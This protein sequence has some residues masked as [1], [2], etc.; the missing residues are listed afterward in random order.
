MPKH[1]LFLIALLCAAVLVLSEG[2]DRRPPLDIVVN[3][4][5][6]FFLIK[7][8]Q[9]KDDVCGGE[10]LDAL[11]EKCLEDN[12]LEEP[13]EGE[14]EEEDYPCNLANLRNEC[15]ERENFAGD[16]FIL[17]PLEDDESK[18]TIT[19]SLSEGAQESQ[20]GLS[21]YFFND[22]VNP[23]YNYTTLSGGVVQFGR[24]GDEEEQNEVPRNSV[25]AENTIDGSHKLEMTVN[26]DCKKTVYAGFFMTLMFA[27]KY[28]PITLTVPVMCY[29]GGCDD[30]CMKHGKCIEN[31]GYCECSPP[32]NEDGKE[33]SVVLRMKKEEYCPGE[34]IEVEL[35]LSKVSKEEWYS[36]YPDW[37]ENLVLDWNYLRDIINSS[38]YELDKP[39]PPAD[40]GSTYSFSIPLMVNPEDTGGV[41]FS[42]YRYADDGDYDYMGYASFTVLRYDDPKCGKP[43]DTCVKSG[44]KHAG[45]KCNEDTG[46][47]ECAD[48]RNFWFDCSRGCEELTVIKDSEGVIDSAGEFQPPLYNTKTTCTWII[49]PEEKDFDY[50]SMSFERF[51]VTN[52]DR[53]KVMTLGKTG[54]IDETSM[55]LGLFSG[56]SVPDDA[57]YEKVEAFGLV[58][59][60]DYSGFGSGFRVKYKT[61]TELPVLG[62]ALG[63]SFAGAIIIIIIVV[64]IFYRR[65]TKSTAVDAALHVLSVPLLVPQSDATDTQFSNADEGFTTSSSDP[66]SDGGDSSSGTGGGTLRNSPSK[67]SLMHDPE[68]KKNT[69]SF[70]IAKQKVSHPTD[71]ES[72]GWT[73][74]STLDVAS[75]VLLFGL[76]SQAT[77]PVMED[78][79]EDVVFTN[80]SSKPLQ[81]RISHPVDENVY[82]CYAQPGM[83]TLLAGC[84]VKVTFH[85]KLKY[86]T[87][88][89]TQFNVEIWNNSAGSTIAGFC[90]FDVPDDKQPDHVAYI[91]TEL[92]GAVSERIDPNEIVLNSEP[93]GVGA[94]GV[95]YPGQYRQNLVAVKVMSRQQEL[96]DQIISDFEKEIELYKRLRNPLLVEFIGASLVP[97]KLCMCTELI[98]HGSLEQLINEVEVPFALQCKFALNIAEAVDYLHAN[99][100]LYRDLKPSNVLIVSTAMGSKV[101]CKIG[102]FGTARDVKDVT[103]LYTYTTGQGTPIYMAP[104]ILDVRPYNNKADVYSYGITLWQMFAREKP[105][106]HVPVWNIPV[107]VISGQRPTC[108]DNMPKEY[109]QLVRSCWSASIDERPN[110]HSVI[111][112]LIPIAKKA[113]KEFKNDPTSEQQLRKV[114]AA[115]S[116]GP[117]ALATVDSVN[118]TSRVIK[119]VPGPNQSFTLNLTDVSGTATVGDKRLLSTRSILS[120]TASASTEPQGAVVPEEVAAK[121]EEDAK[122]NKKKKK[123]EEGASDDGEAAKQAKHSA[124]HSK[125]SSKAKKHS[126]NDEE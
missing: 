41:G 55:A 37:N 14:E 19:I 93:L 67:K 7:N 4:E 65:H 89:Y 23:E 60:T 115:V 95:V 40:D 77:F 79:S 47:C 43:D 59:E 100:V 119:G 8:G 118:N 39:F 64:A 20:S 69:V 3:F 86:T 111:D 31:T 96:F 91:A 92:E 94:F 50:I 11:K 104:E 45:D 114:Q 57:R 32:W 74:V 46:A 36:I 56:Y 124:K 38:D 26:L 72:L 9:N 103:E 25:P 49:D 34:S 98:N 28:D 105:W 81:F 83:G 123:H 101:N 107:L 108:P 24:E 85:F 35:A 116:A 62:I 53:L 68:A 121:K 102:D 109:A 10:A 61:V 5:E 80:K 1:L 122:K 66:I 15:L 58:L 44:C 125:H 73:K 51:Q 2:E 54:T 87:R 75:H 82:E 18:I 16:E 29:E 106:T 90:G 97:G 17:S 112:Q 88:V 126:S 21:F 27:E 48:S 117:A 63:S 22:Y 76:E 12:G 13:E 42:L 6:D 113:K 99:N 70:M 52:G 71:D 110:F 78:M 30:L 84:N 120:S 33:C